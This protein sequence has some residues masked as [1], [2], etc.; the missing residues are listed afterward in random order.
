M[1]SLLFRGTVAALL[2]LL[3]TTI[4]SGQYLAPEDDAPRDRSLDKSIDYDGPIRSIDKPSLH[5]DSPYVITLNA[6]NWKELVEESKLP[7]FVNVGR[8]QCSHCQIIVPLW[9]KF[10]KA[11]QGLAVVASWDIVERNRPKIIFNITG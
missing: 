7:V 2:F 9:E 4:V 8:R 3:G 1:V 5:I 10:A 6:S 11:V